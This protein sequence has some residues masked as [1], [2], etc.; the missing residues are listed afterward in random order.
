L[1]TIPS[2]DTTT[3]QRV[4]NIVEALPSLQRLSGQTI[5][6]KLGGAALHAGGSDHVLA[7]VA[8]LRLLGARP[9]LVHGGG[10]EISEA[11]RRAGIEPRFA[12]GL[13]VTDERSMAIVKAV[14]TEKVGPALAAELERLGA[15]AIAL[16]GED[17][18]TLLVLR[19]HEPG[20]EDLGFVGD[21]V[22]VDPTRIEAVLDEGGIPVVATVGRGGDGHAYNVN[23][24]A[25]AAELAL[26]LDATALVLLTDVPGVRGGDGHLIE[27]LPVARAR[28]L[29][30]SGAVSGGM[31]PKIEA[32]VRALEATSGVDILDGR[33]PHSLLLDLL[34]GRPAGTRV[35]RTPARAGSG[36]GVG[37][38]VQGFAQCLPGAI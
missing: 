34:G 27:E 15:T 23:A 17:G 1:L 5:V 38:G 28:A 31:I 13:R 25:A 22:R 11:Q 7:D 19:H 6:V 20:G 18:P 37:G 35:V 21:V 4:E 3:L 33:V 32:A 30:A 12:H 8:L 10:P 9:V 29:V 26:A 24:D 36:S 16:S 2:T 14:L